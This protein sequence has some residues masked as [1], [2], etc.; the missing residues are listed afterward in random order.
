MSSTLTVLRNRRKRK[1]NADARL[2][3]GSRNTLV[4]CGFIF[5]L[6]LVALIFAVVLGYKNITRDLPPLDKLEKLLNPR[7]GELLQPTRIYDRSG[8]NLITVFAPEDA[9]RRYLPLGAENPQ[10]IPD[11][12]AQATLA[13]AD[14][15]FWEHDGYR[16]ADLTRPEKHPTLAQRL[17]ADLL[18]WDEPPGLRRAV[19]ERLLAAQLTEKYGRQQI[20]EWYLNSANYGR[21][22][23]G[24]EAAAQ[25]YFGKALTELDIAESATLAATGETP[26]LNPLDAPTAAYQHRQ[27]TLYIME[28]LGM[29]EAAQAEKAR[30]T[31]FNLPAA[32]ETPNAA[33]AFVQLTLA[34]LTE[35]YPRERIER[36]GLTIISTLDWDLQQDTRCTLE[37]QVLRLSGGN[38]E[39]CA[40]ASDLPTLALAEQA[41][42]A[43]AS[44]LI[45]NPL[46]G[47][48]LAAVG[49]LSLTGESARL[50]AGKSGS[51]IFPF[52]Y[53]TGFTRGLSPASLLWDIPTEIPV[54]NFDETFHGPVRLR[55]ALANDYV[56]PADGVL[57]QMGAENVQ[58]I[59]RS[60]G[61]N[62][63]AQN[64]LDT[65]VSLFELARA[66][67]IFAAEGTLYGQK[68][69]DSQTIVT[70][71]EMRDA[72]GNFWLDWREAEAQAVVSAQLAY[73]TNNILGDDAARRESL[74]TPNPLEVD[75]PAAAKI[76]QNADA[77]EAWTIGYTP[78][79]VVAVWL[80]ADS[81]VDN[82][83]VAGI[84]HALIK[85][86]SAGLPSLG[87][88]MPVGVSEVE[89]CDPSGLLPTA[90]CPNIVREVFL[91]G[92]EPTQY[93]NLYRSFSV[94]RETGYLAT[95]FT[96]P[97]LVEEQVYL[98]VPEEAQSW[99]KSVG[100][101]E[102]PD[103]Y[104]AI[105][106]PPRLPEAY[107]LAPELFA[108]VRGK[109]EIFG[110]AG[111]EDFE[112]YR[113]QVGQ[114]LNPQR[115]I[116][117]AEM[118]APVQDGLL[119]VWD[120]GELSGL[121][122]IQLLVVHA[123]QS[124]DVTTTQV[125]I[126]NEPPVLQI[127][128]PAEGEVFD[129]LRNRQL[130]FQVSA[131]D[132]LGVA[133]VEYYLDFQQIG[134]LTDAPYWWTWATSTGY[135]HL[136]VI[137]RDRAGNQAEEVVRF[138]V[139]R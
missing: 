78:Q 127:L 72:E 64:P 41:K 129:Y 44:A 137:V 14:P 24:A 71:L 57:R 23:Y 124:V 92:S 22:A 76:G 94:N 81:P 61:L 37:T 88:E 104:D 110:T 89:V 53:L 67:G 56:I 28:N 52:V 113:L 119:A 74:G 33:P 40:A 46:N 97:E 27:E 48:V 51:G 118:H 120:T 75:L 91:S 106:A 117:I 86:A 116:R 1:N 107:F 139:A 115:W 31:P 122:A 39:N 60:F 108:D 98:V 68:I 96:P 85:R 128:S 10:H 7:N 69:G 134:V 34:E 131:D 112:Y 121:Y 63:N 19:R 70:V 87:W 11:T 130:D 20:L 55:V 93:D 103:A 101:A 79:R 5:S 2:Q 13:L 12:L 125:S 138:Q 132:N 102:P 42:N 84:W 6:F 32:P 136:K 105:L 17:V 15:N 47:Q 100:V 38:A 80:G 62:F 73:L 83:A 59:S 111:G 135:H 65:S 99:A 54:Q 8:E 3:R 50:A 77:R 133:A 90:D 21:Y 95:V 126:D 82:K 30:R 123:D 114:G 25:L 9:A 45:L 58:R 4:G 35:V 43:S 29:L 18:L 36:G 26:A 66:Y 109:V 16:L 49:E